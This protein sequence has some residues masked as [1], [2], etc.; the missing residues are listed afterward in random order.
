M[1]TS[2]VKY[3][4]G[5]LTGAWLPLRMM[6]MGRERLGWGGVPKDGTGFD[7]VAKADKLIPSLLF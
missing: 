5:P 7:P 4:A 3:S 1:V 6:S 2:P